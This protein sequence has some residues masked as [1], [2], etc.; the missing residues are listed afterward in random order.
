MRN[1]IGMVL[2]ATAVTMTVYWKMPLY[3]KIPFPGDLLVGRFFP[4]NTMSWEG[5]PTGV[6]YKEFI[7]ADVV[8]QH[9]PWRDLAIS[10]MKHGEIPW[11]NPYAFS[12]SPLLANLQSAPFY[13]LNILYFMMDHRMAWV[14]GVVLQ[15]ILA[16]FWMWLF[17][18]EIGLS[19][20]AAWLSAIAFAFT[21]YM[22][23][24]FELN[25]VGH[26]ALWLP[27]MLWGIERWHKLRGARYLLVVVL[28]AALSL[29]AGH[30]QTTMYVLTI[31]VT[32]ALMRI[33]WQRKFWKNLFPVF[34]SFA[35][36]LFLSAVQL[37]PAIALVPHT[38]RGTQ[39][40]QQIF[41]QFLLPPK[42]LITFLAHDY[43][44]NPAVGN[45]WG[46][47][48][49][50]FMAYFG[51]VALVF[52]CGAL[53]N[54]K[55]RERK[56]LAALAAA[57]LMFALPTP[58]AQLLQIFKVPILSTSAPSRSLFIVQFAGALLA[59]FGLEDWLKRRSM[60]K[61][62][63][64]L[65]G[66]FSLAWLMAVAGYRS[67]H[68][69]VTM[70]N[71]KV[72]LRNL[73]PP[74][75]VFLVSATVI[76]WYRTNAGK[77]RRIS[78][79]V[80][81]AAL[82]FIMMA[83]YSYFANKFQTFSDPEFFFPSSP[84]YQ[85]LNE[86]ARDYPHRFFG[87]YT[88][89]VTSNSWIPYRIYGAEGYDS[90]YLRRYGELLAASVNGSLPASI[91]R[92]D[93]NL[94]K[95]Q[96]EVMRRRLQDLLGVRYILD[97][98]DDPKSGWEP[99]PHR[100]PPE[101]YQ[102]IWQEEKFKVYENTQALPRVMLVGDVIV[103]EDPQRIIDLLMNTEFDLSKRVIL[104]KKLPLKIEPAPGMVKFERYEPNTVKLSVQTQ[105]S[106]L[107][108]LSDAFY[109]D[110]RAYVDEQ[111]TVIYRANYAFRAIVIPP[112]EHRVEFRYQ[113]ALVSLGF[114]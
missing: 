44:G 62:I 70:T 101:R 3:G 85:F 87:D 1:G 48:Y 102:L 56:W 14:I 75:A 23:I 33:G 17:A 99:D 109:P 58:L 22:V 37:V 112:G 67:T 38:P 72:T 86:R 73:I 4:F 65:V 90:L 59:G 36:A 20:P 10:I 80:S 63:M 9:F 81:L 43:F 110:W 113:P 5:Y 92:S 71:W 76:M 74:T 15:P 64:L 95:N 93:A 11:W 111:E 39:A 53:G 61:P 2:L 47:D 52:A 79:R 97:K 107:L 16:M 60:G 31:A 28:A 54:L 46:V 30:L 8:R 105:T 91:P 104:E 98:N 27:L 42:H 50:E 57:A 55:S 51:V 45:F 66:V 100:F 13:P 108:F 29:L 19:R 34:G 21:G 25:T 49:G 40:D 41:N 84:I 83:E 94:V 12:G 77:R 26:A 69:P 18:R 103:E 35:L 78:R 82:F 68:D 7:N 114:W 96:D 24:W 6:A 88:A 89:S 106:Q 32:F